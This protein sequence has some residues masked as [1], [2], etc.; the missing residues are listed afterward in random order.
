MRLVQ[1]HGRINR[2]GSDHVEV[3]IHCYFPDQHLEALL[4]LEERLQRKLKQAA[5]AVGV[6]QVLPG[7][8]GRDITFTET[9]DEIAPLRRE[10]ASL[11]EETGPSA[12]SGEEYRR[13]L[14]R[15]LAHPAV[16]SAVLDLPWGAGTGFSRTGAHQ[17][18]IV[19]CARIADHP[20]PWFRYVP[21]TPELC[22]QIDETGQPVVID[23]ILTCLGHADPGT[24]DAPSLFADGP[25]GQA[26]RPAPPSSRPAPPRLILMAGLD[27]HHPGH[28]TAITDREAAGDDPAD[29]VTHQHVGRADPGVGQ[30]L[31]QLISHVVEGP[32]PASRRVAPPEPRPVIHTPARPRP[33]H[34]ERRA[35]TFPPIA[36]TMTTAGD[37][38]PVSSRCRNRPPTSTS[39]PGGGNRR[40]SRASAA[41]W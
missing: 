12:L 26:R 31:P 18:G 35:S 20:K 29:R 24:P 17:S 27:Q 14:E 3:F 30:V 21:L 22:P 6:G 8:T 5:A 33:A 10:E 40:R 15:E 11:F 13:V 38:E 16:R 36:G 34:G 32:P 41:T 28:V 1:R 25:A 9:R 4:G 37:P 2:I 23:D 7:F 39:C 19:F